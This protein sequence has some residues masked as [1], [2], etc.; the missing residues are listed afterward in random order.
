MKTKLILFVALFSALFV[1]A[2]CLKGDDNE[3]ITYS[4]TAITAFSLGNLKYP[5]HGKTKKGADTIFQVKLTGSNYK[6]YIDQINKEIYNVDSLPYGVNASKILCTVSAKNG[7]AIL[8]KKLTSDSLKYFSTADSIDFSQAREFRVYSRDGKSYRSYTVRV[9]VHK[10]DVGKFAWEQTNGQ[11]DRLGVLSAMKAVTLNGKIYVMGTEGNNTKLYA[12]PNND[13]G[14]WQQLTPNIS[15]DLKAYSNLTV[16]D[17]YLYTYSDSRI[18][19]SRDGVTWETRGA[20][21]LK[22]LAGGANGNLYGITDGGILM[23]KDG[24]TTWQSET[25]ASNSTELPSQNI[26]LFSFPS[27]VNVG[28]YDLV[29]IGNPPSGNDVYGALVWGKQLN[30]SQS[31]QSWIFYGQDNQPYMAPSLTNLQVAKMGEDLIAFGGKGIGKYKAKAFES[32]FISKG[33]GTGWKKDDRLSLPA[34]FESNET[35]FTMTIDENN[36]LWLIAG[37]SGRIWKGN[38]AGLLLKK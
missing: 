17:G 9:N 4:D 19:R 25:L 31:A 23:S 6:F 24:G 14:G 37:G 12:T 10:V 8:Y 38:L 21:V 22:Q 35:S 13:V 34:N 36:N 2:S 28:T 11:D 29:L 27:K 16:S 18:Q 26:S 32:F 5:K 3:T 33:K 1:F 15:L 7:G 20:V 30:S